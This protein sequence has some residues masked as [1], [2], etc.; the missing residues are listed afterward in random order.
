MNKVFK[1][2]I[3][4]L[5][6]EYG[7]AKKDKILENA[8]KVYLDLCNENKDESKEVKKQTFANIYP[9]ISLYKALIKEG[10]SKEDSIHFLDYTYSDRARNKANSLSK[11]LR[12]F[13]LYKIYPS[14]FSKVTKKTFNEASGFKPEFIVSNNKR[15]K[16]NMTKCLYCEVCNRYNMNFLVP[17]FCHTDDANNANLHP[18]LIWHRNSTLG[19]GAEYC[20]FDIFVGNLKKFTK[21][22]NKLC[23]K[24]RKND[25]EVVDKDTMLE[26]KEIV[27]NSVPRSSY[28]V[29]LY[30]AS[31]NV[32]NTYVKQEQN[33]ISYYFKKNVIDVLV[34]T[35]VGNKFKG[36][37][38]Y[39]DKDKG[40]SICYIKIYDIIFSFHGVGTNEIDQKR[41]TNNKAYKKISFDNIRK[42]HVSRTLFENVVKYT[43]E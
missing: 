6:N 31:L 13:G 4:Y 9:S 35:I 19:M 18:N 16:F 41:Y 17:I 32:L 37:S 40:N 36:V 11:I 14:M 43:S 2:T 39:F 10:I 3:P 30:C 38:F 29:L 24:L 8:N 33:D 27:F 12:M 28:E 7:E 25:K 23:Y 20:D 1:E 26:A 15:C 22:L 21:S 34:N 42:Q 5:I